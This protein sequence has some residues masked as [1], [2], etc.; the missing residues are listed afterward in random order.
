MDI[1]VV[2]PAYRAA[3]AVAQRVPGRWV[4]I[5]APHIA[6]V[7]ALRPSERRRMV[8]RH[9]RRV[10][11]SLSDA[12]LE[13]RVR[14]VYRSYGRYYGESFRLPS[15]SPAAL[16]AGV[17]HEG[18]EHI[19][20][21]VAA[22]TGPIL[23]LP[24]LGS[25]EWSAFWLT[26]VKGHKVTAVVERIEPPA[27]YDWFVGFRE[28]IGITVV[29]LGVDAGKAVMTAIKAGHV[30][31]LLSDRDISGGGVEVSFF[32]E[33][34]TLPSGLRCS[35]CAPARRCC[36]PPSTTGGRPATAS[37]GRRSPSSAPAGSGPTWPGSPRRS[38]TSSSC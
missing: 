15:V 25:W 13:R 12:E 30:V 21:A 36:R 28:Q 18:Y 10:D 20:R 22:G 16:D 27:L 23:V 26:K 5:V 1:D 35:P 8:E 2:T 32:G 3:A 19:E 11:P 29:P 37:C 33:K 34:T 4:D 24:H 9:Q 38:P 31:T 14:G 6:E 7:A 17:S